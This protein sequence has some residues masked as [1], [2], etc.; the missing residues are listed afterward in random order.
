MKKYPFTK[1]QI[2][3]LNALK[4]GKYKKLKGFLG[5]INE[6]G[7]V[8]AAC[9]LGVACQTICKLA[10]DI[11]RVERKRHYSTDKF[12]ASYDDNCECLPSNVQRIL[13][14]RGD[15]GELENTAFY[16]GKNYESLS[17]MNDC[18]ITHKQ[19]A[20]YI[21]QNPWNVFQD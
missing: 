19:I 2:S 18:N 7:A 6:K 8:Y 11:L 16:K 10:P 4:S 14:L 9:C 1:L 3:W 15:L 12:V 21:E 13:K 17:E 5:A 20:E